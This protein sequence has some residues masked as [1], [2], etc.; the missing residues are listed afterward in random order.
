MRGVELES[1]HSLLE[2]RYVIRDQHAAWVVLR[3]REGQRAEMAQGVCQ[4]PQFFL[5][6]SQVQTCAQGGIEAIRFAK[7]AASLGRV[8]SPRCFSAARKRASAGEG[9][10]LPDDAAKKTGAQASRK[11]THFLRIPPSLLAKV[12]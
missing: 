12:E 2:R 1:R 11:T 5:A 4:A 7:L 9:S 6:E 3:K 8:A 10:A